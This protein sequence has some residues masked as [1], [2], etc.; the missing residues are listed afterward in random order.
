MSTVE[1]GQDTDVSTP[2]ATESV[3]VVA[4]YQV[5]VVQELEQG[6]PGPQGP[7]GTPS[8]IPGPQGPKGDPGNTVL[9]GPVDPV[10]SDGVNG[11]FYINTTTHFMFGPKAANV[12]PAGTSLIG[13]QGVPGNTILYG[14][15]D[16][17]GAIGIN[18]N[19]YINTTTHFMFG[20]KA[21]GAWLPG[22]S[23]VGPQGPQGNQG[24]QGIQGNTGQ[25]GSAFYTGAGAPG[26]ISGQLNGD[27]YLNTTNGDVYTLTAGAWG[28][29]VGNIRGPQGV[30]GPPGAGDVVGPAGA[31]D[32][33][34]ATFN[35]ATGK[36]VKDSGIAISGGQ[37]SPVSFIAGPTGKAVRLQG[38][39]DASEASLWDVGEYQESAA[40]T[41]PLV[42]NAISNP[43]WTIPS[44]GDWDLMCHF[45]FSGGGATQCTD[46]QAA[47]SLTG[48]NITDTTPGRRFFYRNNSGGFTL[49][50]GVTGMLY[51]RTLT[52]AAQQ[53]YFC[54][55]AVFATS[56]MACTV[57]FTARRRR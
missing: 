28:S 2:L 14:A 19:F 44:A 53:W 18:G 35:G 45:Y 27:N 9:Y 3:I 12:W 50:P 40:T 38:V 13:P 15:A 36:L 34:V 42:S 37:M 25:R 21:G 52:G 22:T 57:K 56:T 48:D 29:P 33:R 10:N 32:N 4:D 16:P 55:R 41:V 5:E 20:P 6:P 49:D 24:N 17:T 23:L 54:V 11:D 43:T 47:L 30:Q 51:T 8:T 46:I 1:V 39:Q 7:Q 31:T 26:A